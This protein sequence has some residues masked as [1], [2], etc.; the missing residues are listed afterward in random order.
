[1]VIKSFQKRYV[2]VNAVKNGSNRNS[3][4]RNSVAVL[5]RVTV[6]TAANIY[7]HGC[8]ITNLVNVVK[9]D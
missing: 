4:K 9:K 6:R 8:A 7:L 5:Q 2:F 1:M 3:S